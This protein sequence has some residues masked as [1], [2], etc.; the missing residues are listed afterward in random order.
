MTD[1]MKKSIEAYYQNPNKCKFCNNIIL[2]PDGVKP[3][4]IKK[5]KY[6]NKLCIK[7]HYKVLFPK[8][9]KYNNFI[10]LEDSRKIDLF[11]RSKNWQSARS[12][13][14]QAARNK[15]RNSNKSKICVICGYDK[16]YEVCH[17]NSVSNFDNDTLIGE[18]NNLDNLI[19]LCPNCHWEFDNGLLMLDSAFIL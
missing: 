18:I 15:Y 12:T 11:I 7:E 4:I 17:I 16:Y 14:Q 3:S 19:A 5:Q 6:C 13:I 10:S 2:I 9:E 8:K 1:R